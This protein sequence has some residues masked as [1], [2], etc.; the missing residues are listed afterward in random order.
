MIWNLIIS[1]ALINMSI[2][3][4]YSVA[5]KGLCYDFFETKLDLT[6]TYIKLSNK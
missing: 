6:L 1:I 3:S 5:A 4:V 2:T